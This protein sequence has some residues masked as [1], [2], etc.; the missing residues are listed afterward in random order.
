MPQPSK[1]PPVAR[2]LWR[3]PQPWGDR[4]PTHTLPAPVTPII[5]RE[6]EIAHAREI[7]RRDD[8]RLLTIT[9]PGG[10]GKTRLGIEVAARALGAFPDGICFVSLATIRDAALVLPSIAQALGLRESLGQSPY[11]RVADNLRARS[12]LLVLDNFEHLLSEAL[13]VANLLAQCPQLTVLVT[14]RAKL[15]LRGEYVLPVPPLAVPDVAH[16]SDLE[17]VA[18]APAIALYC[19]CASA[20]SATFSLTAENAAAVAGICARLDG[21]PLALELA[22]A[23]SDTLPPAAL[24]ERLTRRLSALTHS[25]RDMPARQRTMRDAIAWSYD[26]LT[27]EE[28]R[29]FRQLAVFVG[30]WTLDGARAVTDGACNGDV[31]D[32]IASLIGK[33]LVSLTTAG[34]GAPRYAMLETI[35]EYGLEQLTAHGEEQVLGRAHTAYFRTVV[36]GMERALTGPAQAT[37]TARLAADLENLRAAMRWT[38]THGE[39]GWGLEFGW[40]LWRFWLERGDYTEGRAWLTQFLAPAGAAARGTLYGRAAFAAGAL[41]VDQRDLDAARVHLEQ[42]LAIGTTHEDRA[43]V[44]SVSAQLGRLAR[45]QSD[46]TAA[47]SYCEASLAIRRELGVPWHIAVSLQLAGRV[48]LEQRDTAAARTHL[49]EGMAIARDAGD[50]SLRANLLRD[51]GEVAL[52]EEAYDEAAA[53]FGESLAC[54]RAV[55]HPWSMARCLDALADITLRQGEAMRTARLLGAAAALRATIDVPLMAIDHQRVERT[56]TAARAALGAEWFT[57]AWEAGGRLPL[58]TV[59]AEARAEDEA[60][61]AS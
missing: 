33:S 38:V 46:L 19:R 57:I 10:V 24:L 45:Q 17:A 6:W 35:R 60:M 54:Y 9:G 47:R 50:R 43:L 37:A 44:A 42:A 52:T 51:L 56:A 34:E 59:I 4:R 16:L 15:D 29:L 8:T 58:E 20:V 23:H 2:T 30:G 28:Q 61:I 14:S 31:L 21:L 18:R 39:T 13:V 3:Q 41:A 27:D 36:A 32:G 12:L 48:A 55:G 40:E 5:G 7:L 49:A 1:P 53:L 11:E 22:A 25:K 26:L